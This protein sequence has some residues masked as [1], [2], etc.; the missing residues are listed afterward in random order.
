MPRQ[1]Q[2]PAPERFVPDEMRGQLVQAEQVG[3]YR[4]AASF[5]AGR[6]VLDAGCGI[7]YGSELLR[8]AGAS[9]VV[10]LD[11]SEAALELAKSIV[12]AGVTCELGDVGSLSHDD[13][14]FDVIVCFDVIEQVDD[15][16]RVLDELARV[17]RPGG[18]LL[19]STPNRD[20]DIPGNPHH[21][22]ELVRSELQAVL[23]AR[24]DS[25][26]IIS[27]YVMLASVI[28]WSDSPG[29][30]GAETERVIEA[31]PEDEIHLLAMAGSELVPDPGPTVTLARFAEA[32][33]WLD[34]IELQKRY[35]LDQTQQL[36]DLAGRE[37]DRQAALDRLT[38]AEQELAGLR[39]QQADLVQTREE[40]T[41]ASIELDQ[42]RSM[43]S[44]RSWQLAD[45]LRRLAAQV[46]RR[47][48]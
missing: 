35:I 23:D 27:Q 1:T 26:R 16:E 30:D 8:R 4:W 3:R 19:I 17:L 13:D 12:S 31:E 7:G 6:R 14:S 42:L 40:L 37:V 11:I 46:R 29:F 2:D 5:C 20:R 38:D 33:R 36:Q 25:A 39:T 48:P 10:A 28:S 24:F 47:R 15:L 22:R 32:R 45:R 9:D 34:H 18:L 43:A 41:A 21:Q 44:T